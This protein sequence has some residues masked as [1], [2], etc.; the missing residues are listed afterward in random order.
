MKT[1]QLRHDSRRQE[2]A[3]NRGTCCCIASAKQ[4]CRRSAGSCT[5]GWNW[6]DTFQRTTV[7]RQSKHAS[8]AML[9]VR[10]RGGRGRAVRRG[11]ETRA[12]RERVGG[13]RGRETRAEL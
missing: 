9:A 6:T 12:E 3:P 7:S 10:G 8:H 13:R 5:I 1:C 2:T 11:R 4:A